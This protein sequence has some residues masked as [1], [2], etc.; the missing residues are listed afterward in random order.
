MMTPRGFIAI[1]F[2]RQA[3]K[4]LMRA[5]DT[6]TTAEV[7]ALALTKLRRSKQSA[8]NALSAKNSAKE[9]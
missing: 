3:V 4:K 9:K 1:V 8:R 5:A 2:I 6:V 7:D